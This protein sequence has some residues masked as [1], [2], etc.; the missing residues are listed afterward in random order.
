MLNRNV[1]YKFKMDAYSPET[2]P[3]ARLA[4]YLASLS[5]LFGEK[6]SVHFV[7]IEPGSAVPVIAVDWEDEPKIQRRVHEARNDDGPEDARKA[8]QS[9]NAKLAEDNASAELI[10]PEGARILQFPGRKKAQALEYGP[11]VQPGTL[12]GV[13]ARIGGESAKLERV[14]VHIQDSDGRL[15]VCRASREM[16]DRLSPFM[17]KAPIRV[18][19][20]GKWFRPADGEWD[21]REFTILDF[22]PLKKT[23]L[24]EV[25]KKLRQI[26]ANWS[27][28]DIAALRHDPIES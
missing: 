23:T 27:V 22:E 24:S 12:D 9:I 2:L 21:M 19:G 6:K 3:M 25:V 28:Q 8:I 11:I 13:I 10:G 1:E 20:T 17:L 26:P 15:H 16:V 5:V 7:R 4:E 18:N 14:P